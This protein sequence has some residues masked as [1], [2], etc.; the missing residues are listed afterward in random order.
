MT[1]ILVVDDSAVDR[2]LAGGL[3]EKDPDLSI[4]YAVHGAD[5]LAK[6]QEDLPNL[7][8]TDL[9]MPEM[10]GLELVSMVRST[11][12]SVP[13]ILMTS[14]GNEEI[15]MQAL[16]RGASSYVPKRVLS[17]RLLETVRQ[18]LEIA[19]HEQ[20]VSRLMG[21]LTETH[22]KFELDNDNRLIPPLVA[23]LLELAERLE[24]WDESDRMRIGI[25][26]EESL[27]N[28]LCHGN[29]EVGSELRGVDD[30]AYYALLAT[31]RAC[32]PHCDRRIHIDALFSR[33]LAQFVIRDEGPGFDPESLPDPTDPANLEKAAGRGVLLMRSFMDEV[34]YNPSG[35]Q[36][37]LVKR[38]SN[39][40]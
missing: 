27:V 22:C 26:L 25:A 4:R 30:D 32:P 21:C 15:C 17:Q 35:N 23:H 11:Y 3:L 40:D 16:Q 7:V 39:K 18:V 19:S 24:L 28:A 2:R 6:M 34:S 20:T 36:V 37:T 29:L 31:R 8:L 14:A 1:S 13:V 10:D 38:R 9:V 33:E 5:G 12:P